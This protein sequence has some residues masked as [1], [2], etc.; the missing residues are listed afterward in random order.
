MQPYIIHVRLRENSPADEK[1]VRY[2]VLSATAAEALEAVGRGLA[3]GERA[4]L[5]DET[6]GDDQAAELDLIA[7]KARMIE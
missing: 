2:A 7:G 4:S 6:L 1:T 5:S 3:F